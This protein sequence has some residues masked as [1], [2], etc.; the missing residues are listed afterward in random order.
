MSL[1]VLD[2]LLRRET[3]VDQFESLIWTERFAAHGDFELVIES[4]SKFRSLLKP[5]VRLGMDGSNRVMVIDTIQD[6][7]DD[8]GKK[9]LTIEGRD[10]VACLEER[11]A[12]P[13][14]EV[15]LDEEGNVPTW[16]LT[17]LPGNIARFVFDWVAREGNVDV[18]DIIPFLVEGSL[19][20]PST[21]PE[22]FEDV[23]VQLSPGTLYAV[24]KEICEGFGLGFRLVK[25]LDDSK[26]YFDIYSGYDR[27]SSQTTY[28][29]VLF[30]QN[31]DNLL[32][33]TE[34]TSVAAYK[35]VAYVIYKGQTTVVYSKE[36]GGD[37]TG[38][39]RRVMLVELGTVPEF[40]GTAPEIAAQL[41]EFKI[42]AGN[43]ALAQQRIVSMFD[44]EIPTNGKYQYTI[45]YELGDMVEMR[46]PDGLTKNM[47]VSENIRVIDAEGE[48]SYP[49]LTDVLYITP[50]SWYAWDYNQVW[51]DA[52]GTW[53]EA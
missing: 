29:A 16:D 28:P 10:L 3:I 6:K 5:D 35:N 12:I 26:L 24:M 13:T 53:E 32:N 44:G 22:P 34:L 38:F 48:R 20:P 14:L 9:T 30:S 47:R 27:T 11:I 49:T 36:V 21:V 7:L 43:D 4:T 39:E 33:I 17:G 2:G 19:Y 15:I 25:G 1:H 8:D 51:D 45:H 31:L 46:T 42:K 50:G 37:I 52:E 40:T 41:E 18:N 23:L